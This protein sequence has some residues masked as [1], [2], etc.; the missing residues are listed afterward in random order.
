M[1]GSESRKVQVRFERSPA[2]CQVP[3][4]GAWLGLTASGEILCQFYVENR[5]LPESIE[6]TVSQDGQLGDQER[7]ETGT[8]T[9]LLQVGVV[10]SVDAAK[11]IGQF[12]IDVDRHFELTSEAK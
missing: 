9:R 5:S 10:M 7:K 8:F 1:E 6:Y 4:T 3:A 11:T 2:Y 12:L